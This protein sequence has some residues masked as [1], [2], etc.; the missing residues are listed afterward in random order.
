M[1]VLVLSNG[2]LKV[3]E[4]GN[5]LEDLQKIV[6]GYIEIPFFF[7]FLWDNGIDIVIFVVGGFIEGAIRVIAILEEE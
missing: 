1:K 4:I 2:E 5:S 3:R 6:G 7:F